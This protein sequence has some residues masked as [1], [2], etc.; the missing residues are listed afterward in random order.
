MALGKTERAIKVPYR[1]TQYN[2]AR[3]VQDFGGQVLLAIV[4]YEEKWGK[5]GVFFSPPRE[6]IDRWEFVEAMENG[7]SGTLVYVKNTGLQEFFNGLSC[8]P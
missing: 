1:E 3:K 5:Y 7:R 2:W 4:A 6:F 8:T